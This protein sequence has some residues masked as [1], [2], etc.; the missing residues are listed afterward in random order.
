MCS[1]DCHLMEPP[2]LWVEGL[3]RS[4]RD[5]APRYEYTETHRI[6]HRD[7]KAFL[8]EPLAIEG[9]ADGTPI[10]DDVELRMK[11]LAE[12]GIWAE[13]IFGNMGTF[14]LGAEDP[15]YAMA[16]ARVFNDYLADAYG[17]YGDRELPVAMVPVR[18][19]GAAVGEIERVVELGLRSVALPM[20][21]PTPYFL[22]DYDPIWAVAEASGI[23]LCFH[24]GTGGDPFGAG[25]PIA[26]A[27]AAAGDGVLSPRF[28][29][30]LATSVGLAL[31]MAPQQLV[32]TMV[33][34]GVLE[35]HPELQVLVV[36]AGAG[37]LAP[38]MEAMDFAW[39]PKTGHD[40]ESELPV[41]IDEAGNEV[42]RGFNFKQGGWKYSMKP[43]DYARR[44]VKVTFM[45]EPAPLR[46]LEV[47][48]TEPLL[49]G[50]DFPHPE[51]TW[52]RSREVT[53][54][55]FAGV[56]QA[57]KDAIVGGNLA[58]IFDLELPAV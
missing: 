20:T 6:W 34:S 7:G 27:A 42:A 30:V 38:L 33:A 39:T 9:R 29:D 35:R 15:E 54:R 58:G 3:P 17:P 26:A 24:V 18:D 51:G 46:F 55:L 48:G 14:C 12:D 4:M 31:Q 56:D 28:G 10:T 22:E 32:V 47:T 1:A 40:R 52:P 23:P 50:S 19:V 25:N 41:G 49:W 13:L 53:D 5:R 37:W 2:D 36:E 21:P 57:D 44:Q 16:C 43:S 45:D 8:K 11:E